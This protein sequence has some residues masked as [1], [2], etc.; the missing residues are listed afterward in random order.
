MD[1]G[2]EYRAAGGVWNTDATYRLLFENLSTG[3]SNPAKPVGGIM[4]YPNPVQGVLKTEIE[5]PGGGDFTFSLTDVAGKTVKTIEAY[6]L[7]A[8][9][10]IIEINIDDVTPGI[11]F[12]HCGGKTLKIIKE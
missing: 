9:K 5:T 12:M 6:N 2:Y 8:G 7:Q 10:E 11:Y 3:V 1:T 4:V